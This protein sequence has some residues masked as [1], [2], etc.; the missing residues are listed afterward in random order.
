MPSGRSRRANSQSSPTRA[1]SSLRRSSRSWS[2]F[3]RGE[4]DTAG[5]FAM[6]TITFSYDCSL[7]PCRVLE[8]AHDFTDRRSHVFP[9]VEAEHF[10]VHSIADEHAD[11]TEGTGTGIGVSWE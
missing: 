9:A 6:R 8:A 7:P 4:S 3:S 2:S 5:G 1:T 11:V 10:E